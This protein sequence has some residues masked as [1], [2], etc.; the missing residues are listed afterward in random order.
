MVEL[1]LKYSKDEL[2]NEGGDMAGLIKSYR[3]GYTKVLKEIQRRNSAKKKKKKKN[4]EKSHPE[5]LGCH[6]KVLPT[7][8]ERIVFGLLASC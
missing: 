2:L 6:L 4:D 8:H 5:I 1:I 7:G 3:G